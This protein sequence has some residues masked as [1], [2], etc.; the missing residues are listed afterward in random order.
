MGEPRVMLTPG[1]D[2]IIM[3]AD[4][5]GEDEEEEEAEAED[6]QETETKWAAS[7][8]TEDWDAEIPHSS[9]LP[10]SDSNLPDFH[11]A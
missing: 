9:N 3:P 4:E 5:E 1:R 10:D 2:A 7:V 11:G 6:G 8:A